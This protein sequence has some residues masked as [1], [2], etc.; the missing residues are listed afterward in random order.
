MA[1]ILDMQY[2]P[3]VAAVKPP[4]PPADEEE[5]KQHAVSPTTFTQ[6]V[7]AK[8][9]VITLFVLYAVIYALHVIERWLKSA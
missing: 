5:M 4:P 3:G 7:T 6:E 1:T 8:S 9:I 2:H